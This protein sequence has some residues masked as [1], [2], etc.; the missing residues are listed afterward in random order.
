MTAEQWLAARQPAPPEPLRER[1][2]ERLRGVVGGAEAG[3]AGA[4]GAADDVP[5]VL[6][7]RGAAALAGV[8]DGDASSRDCARSLLAADALVTYAFEA[9]AET[10]DGL[11]QRARAAIARLA[12][13]GAGAES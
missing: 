7:E 3:A 11:E 12:A 8:L 13:L 1:L 5:S 10:P 2:R 9:A 4:T 6:L